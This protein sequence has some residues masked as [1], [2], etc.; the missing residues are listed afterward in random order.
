MQDEDAAIPEVAAIGEV[1]FGRGTV[2][3]FEEGI[4][5]EATGLACQRGAAADVAIAGVR[6]G[7]H[8]AEE[9][10]LTRCRDG[11]RPLQGADERLARPSPRGRTAS[12]Q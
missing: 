5:R 4:D 11:G 7:R 12:R 3:L 1:G 8:D 10:E 6:P 9:N 2:G